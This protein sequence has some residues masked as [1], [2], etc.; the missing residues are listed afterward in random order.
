MRDNATK[1]PI[2]DAALRNVNTAGD[3]LPRLPSFRPVDGDDDDDS[4]DLA[5]AARD[6]RATVLRRASTDVML[7][8]ETFYHV[9]R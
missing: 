5:P 8:L 4:P 6:D 1:A 2:L 3:G 9:S 7:R